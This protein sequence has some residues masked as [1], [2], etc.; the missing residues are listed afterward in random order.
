MTGTD[1]RRLLLES[2]QELIKTPPGSGRDELRRGLRE[3]ARELDKGQ[4]EAGQDLQLNDR[5]K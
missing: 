2:Q 3:T 5:D 4:L 1:K